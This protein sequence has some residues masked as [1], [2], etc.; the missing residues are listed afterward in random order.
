MRGAGDL[1]TKALVV[2]QY[3]RKQVVW[4]EPGGGGGGGPGGVVGEPGVYGRG[5]TKLYGGI[6]GGTRGVLGGT[7]CMAEP[8]VYT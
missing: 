7:G 3:V 1:P 8:G 4:A 2:W 5:G 6:R